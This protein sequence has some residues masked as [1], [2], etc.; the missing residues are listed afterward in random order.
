MPS[1]SGD[2]QRFMRMAY[3]RR[4][5]GHPRSTDPKM[6]LASLHDFTHKVPGAPERKNP[7]AHF[8]GGP[9]RTTT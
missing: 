2:Q 9:V 4:M 7:P 1:V 3:Q 8:G 5:A 6:S